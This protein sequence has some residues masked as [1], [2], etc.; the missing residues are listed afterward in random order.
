MEIIKEV[1][2]QAAQKSGFGHSVEFDAYRIMLENFAVEIAKF[3]KQQAAIECH[4]HY[5]ASIGNFASAHNSGVKKCIES[6]EALD[7]VSACNP[8][9]KAP[10]GFNRNSSHNAD[11]YVCECE[12]WEPYEAGYDAG[13]Q[14]GLDA[15]Y[16]A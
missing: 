13:F 15:A 5:A 16:N 12:S 10:H 6:I 8:H 11:R 9:P 3:V 4:K 7:T 14:A 2:V 1:V